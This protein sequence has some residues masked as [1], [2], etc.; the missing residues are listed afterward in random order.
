MEEHIDYRNSKLNSSSCLVHSLRPVL[1]L[2]I[3]QQLYF[4][5]VHSVLNYDIMFWD[6]SPHSDLFL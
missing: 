2:E 4:S 3:L 1:E 6:N 5:Y